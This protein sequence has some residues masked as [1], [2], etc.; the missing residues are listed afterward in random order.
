MARAKFTDA[1]SLEVLEQ[2]EILGENIRLARKSRGWSQSEAAERFLMSK[3]T[4]VSVE[5]GDPTTS[6][7]AYLA[8]LDTMG[9]AQGIDSIG[10]SHRDPIVRRGLQSGGPSRQKHP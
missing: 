1:L 3:V 7:G 8:A 2:L 9:I 5:R 4:L 6:I 10:A